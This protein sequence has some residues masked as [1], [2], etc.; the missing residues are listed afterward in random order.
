MANPPALPNH[1]VSNTTNTNFN[2]TISVYMSETAAMALIEESKARA[3]V[4]KSRYATTARQESVRVGLVVC[5]VIAW[6]MVSKWLGLPESIM[7][8]GMLV[9]GGIY[10]ISIVPKAIEKIRE[11]KVLNPSS[12]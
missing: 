4:A 10:G 5:G 3:S 6:G 7:K 9:I 11:P 8:A 2:N 12:Q 1:G